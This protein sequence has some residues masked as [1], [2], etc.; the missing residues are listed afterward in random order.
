MTF[1]VGI[2]GG[3][4]QGTEAACLA[5]WA[6]WESVLVDQRPLAPAGGVA[7]RFT[8]L[9]IESPA[10]LDRAFAGCDLVVPACE[11][12]PTLDLLSR[13]GRAGGRPVAFDPEAYRLSADKARSKD[14][15]LR[16]GAPTPRGWPQAEYP[17]I[18]KPVSA[19]GSRG[20]RLLAGPDD[21]HPLFPE[22]DPSGWVVEEYCPGPS[23]SLEVTGR[24]GHYRAWLTTALEMDEIYDCRQVRSPAGLTAAQELYFREISLKIAETLGL[25]GLMDV[26]VILAPQGFRVLEIDARLPSQTPTVVWWATGENLLTRLAEIFCVL[27]AAVAAPP[28]PRAVIYEHVAVGPGGAVLTG[29]HLMASA[30]PLSLKENF[31]GADWVVTDWAPGRTTWAAT[32]IM[33][34]ADQAEV[35]TKRAEVLARVGCR[36]LME[37]GRAGG[38]NGF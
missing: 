33:T 21:F 4:L 23:Y 37:A 13:W 27:P 24:P 17:L 14:L 9:K 25:Y 38:S 32:L 35:R 18:A 26:E 6:G 15:F 8:A 30:G 20:V 34:G 22:G 11:D 12:W 5:R 7:D 2:L 29:E 19:S 1:R 31:L 36:E 16:A 10:D 28:A 3:G